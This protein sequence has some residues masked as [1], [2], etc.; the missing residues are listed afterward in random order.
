MEHS[1]PP[2]PS[3][4]DVIDAYWRAPLV[5]RLV[6]GG[7]GITLLALGAWQRFVDG[8]TL[9]Y[10]TLLLGVFLLT[11]S[12][13]VQTLHALLLTWIYRQACP[14]RPDARSTAT[15]AAPTGI[16]T[17]RSTASRA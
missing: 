13:I 12:A 10:L 7:L 8:N 17:A 5:Q 1:T 4:L 3:L 6:R 16:L 14:S 9:G 2:S 15:I 11:L